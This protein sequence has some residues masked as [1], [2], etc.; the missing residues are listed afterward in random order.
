MLEVVRVVTDG[1]RSTVFGAEDRFDVT[2]TCSWSS[3]VDRVV[4]IELKA[5]IGADGI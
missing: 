5:M 4:A 1:G 2:V 3:L